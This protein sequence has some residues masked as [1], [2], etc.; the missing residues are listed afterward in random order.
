LNSTS[1]ATSGYWAAAP[2]STVFSVTTSAYTNN[3]NIV[4]YCFAPIAGYSAFGSYTGNGS[5]DG[6]FVYTGMRV[7]WLMVKCS[8]STDGGNGDWLMYDTS[9]NSYN[10]MNSRLWADLSSAEASASGYYYDFLSN[11]FKVRTGDANYGSN[12]SGQTYIYAAFA[13]NP[14][15]ISRAR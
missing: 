2:T 9:R 15:N 10:V 4:A 13:E 14:F 11:G 6:P 5:T 8:S 7:R 12:T 1:A 3:D